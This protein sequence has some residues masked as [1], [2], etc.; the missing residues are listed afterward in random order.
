MASGGLGAFAAIGTFCAFTVGCRFRIVLGL[1]LLLFGGR[2]LGLEA[3]EQRFLVALFEQVEVA[4]GRLDILVNNAATNPYFGP[5]TGAKEAAWDK[6]FDVNLKGPFFMIQHAAGLMEKG[7][8][9]SIVNVASVNGLRPAVFQ[10]IY[11]ITKAGVIAMTRAYAK[12]LAS[13]NIRVN[14][15]VPGLTE[16]KFASALIENEEIY[17]SVLQRIPMQRHAQ[18]DE[19]AGA[20][21]YLV[22][23]M[24]S[25]T[26][27]TT[28]VCDGGALA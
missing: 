19:M 26:T 7:G 23:D 8:G 3:L 20:V 13:A 2:M 17:S 28:I 18:P 4:Y 1:F 27:G 24:A 22:S 12:E 10:G 14:A 16:T 15:L 11:S 21:L 9:G 25:F 5:M 6:T